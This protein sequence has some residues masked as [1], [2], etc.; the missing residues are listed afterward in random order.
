MIETLR[1]KSIPV[2]VD[3][4][5]SITP[6]QRE[7]L[8]RTLNLLPP[9]HLDELPTIV[10]G[11]RPAGGAGGAVPPWGPGG[12]L[13]RIHVNRFG[14]SF[15]STYNLTLL[16]EIG[17]IMDYAYKCIP[18]PRRTGHYFYQQSEHRADLNLFRRRAREG[19]HEGDTQG[20]NE[21]YA[22]LY[23]GLLRHSRTPFNQARPWPDVQA[24]YAAVLRS[25]PFDR[26][27]HAYAASVGVPAH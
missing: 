25:P 15:N 20:E 3:F 16:H 27:R 9:E 6:V 26:C 5:R 2:T 7:A 23:S 10:I 8:L 21:I 14:A 12:P 13:I 11:D 24:L 17:H 1:V 22:D 4:Q 18:V 19:W